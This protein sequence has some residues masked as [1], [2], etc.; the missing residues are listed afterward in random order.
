MARS[1]GR[2][3]HAIRSWL[4]ATA[5]QWRTYT[6]HEDSGTVQM[7]RKLKIN[8]NTRT[9]IHRTRACEPSVSGEK[10]APRALKL[11][12]V[13]S[14]PRTVPAPLPLHRFLTRVHRSA[15]PD[16]RLAPLRFPLRSH[17]SHALHIRYNNVARYA[18][19]ASHIIVSDM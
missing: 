5:K 13:T 12:S 3:W 15:P 18:N 10:A 17:G 11:I 19:S 7:Y 1:R 14:A 16:F 4:R 6:A 2:I 9:T 8:D